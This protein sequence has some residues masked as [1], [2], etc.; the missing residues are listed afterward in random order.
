MCRGTGTEVRIQQIFPGMVQHVEQTCRQCAGSGE[1]IAPKDRCKDC[2]GK[3]TIRTRDVLEVHIERGMPHGK[4]LTF[5]GQGNEEP[6]IE[7]GDI[8][9]VL[10][11]KKHPVF[12]RADLDL[13]ITIPLIL[14][15]ALCGFKKIIKTLDNRDLMLT[16]LAGEVIKNNDVKCILAEGM[17]QWKNPFE[18]G[19]LIIQFEVIFPTFIAPDLVPKLESCLPPRPLLEISMDAEEC[20]L[21]SFLG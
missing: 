19:R 15:E 9:V 12:R 4:K 3:K 18:K 8:V 7:P 11:E 14:T 6:G 1:T 2:N 10:N 17:P 21:V 5:K 16:H 13:L 20:T